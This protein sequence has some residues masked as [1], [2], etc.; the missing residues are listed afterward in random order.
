MAHNNKTNPSWYEI[1]TTL[2]RVEKLR[3]KNS[4]RWRL[5]TESGI[6]LTEDGSQHDNPSLD[7]YDGPIILRLQGDRVV[8]WEI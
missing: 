7:K 3:Q 4:L 2:L 5:Y 6:Y 1:S 8:G